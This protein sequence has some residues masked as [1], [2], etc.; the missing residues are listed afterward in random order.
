MTTY[1]QTRALVAAHV[2]RDDERFRAVVAQIAARCSGTKAAALLQMATA[3]PKPL[4]PL[5]SAVLALVYDAPAS[6]VKLTLPAAVRD[7][8]AAVLREWEGASRLLEAGLRARSRLLF[9][10]PPGNGKTT[11]AAQHARALGLSAHVC[12]VSAVRSSYLGATAKAIDQV[13]GVLTAGQALILDELDALGAARFAGHSG[14]DA[15]ANRSV[16]T[17]L[18]GL[19]RC[20]S[21]LLLATTNRLD[22]VDPALVRRFDAT[23]EFPQPT[24]QELAGFATT[25][26]SQWGLDTVWPVEDLVGCCSYDDAT[27][28]VHKEA[29]RAILERVHNA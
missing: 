20:T 23:I 1:A 16:S 2:A 27:K 13:M 7:E 28:R 10:G 26:R 25:L 19:D 3:A 9:W 22:I 24:A 6:D 12:S 18:T 17:L 11:A 4:T 14:A 15:E 21:G 29:R 5:P 8:L